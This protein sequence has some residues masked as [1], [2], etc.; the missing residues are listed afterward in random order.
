[1]TPAETVAKKRTRNLKWKRS[2]NGFF[3]AAYY[4]I[5]SRCNDKRRRTYFGLPFMSR[6]DWRYFLSDTI[7]DRKVLH[8]EWIASGYQLRLAPSID[9][10]D[11]LKGYLPDNC[12][13]IPQWKNCSLSRQRTHCLRG[14][15]LIDGNLYYSK[16]DRKHC[17]ACTGIRD[18]EKDTAK[19]ALVGGEL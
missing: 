3:N 19:Q 6:D 15:A 16:G 5:K 12:Q 18:R 1:M 14:H 8:D 7:E 4:G 13:W 2:F 11:H 9:R 10:K 17:K